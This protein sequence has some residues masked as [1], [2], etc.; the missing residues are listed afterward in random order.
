MCRKKN[1]SAEPQNNAREDEL[2]SVADFQLKKPEAVF[3]ENGNREYFTEYYNAFKNDYIDQYLSAYNKLK[4]EGKLEKY[5]PVSD[6][7][8]EETKDELDI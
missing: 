5:S 4:K 1:N 2:D 8:S 6:S 3:D 7:E